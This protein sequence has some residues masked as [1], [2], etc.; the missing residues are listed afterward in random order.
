MVLDGEIYEVERRDMEDS[1]IFEMQK[2]PDGTLGFVVQYYDGGC[3]FEE[4]IE[5][6]HKR[7]SNE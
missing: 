6:A 5:T 1:D 3:G 2:N 4:A 7:M